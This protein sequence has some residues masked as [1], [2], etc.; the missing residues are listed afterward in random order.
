MRDSTSIRL[1]YALAFGVWSAALAPAC[2]SAPYVWVQ[3]LPP[4]PDTTRRGAEIEIGDSLDV[5]V[6]GQDA[7]RSTQKVAADGTI[8]VP[9]LGPVSVVGL[10]PV[11]LAAQ[12]T[13]RYRPFLNDPRVTVV[14]HD[15]QVSVTVVGEVEKVGVVELPPP[16]SVLQLIAKVGGLGK[17]AHPSQIFVLRNDGSGQV[18][19]I[20]FT[21]D[22][23]LEGEPAATAFRLH[24]GDTLVV[25]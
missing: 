4:R 22:M 7:L 1:I 23:L 5:S 17:F 25:Q 10:L 9:L 19:R 3:D 8:T 11:G 15:A 21:Y 24:T 18:R 13:D 2:R 12:L 14:M 6:F 16:V 20:R